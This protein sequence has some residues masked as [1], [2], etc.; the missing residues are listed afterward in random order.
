MAIVRVVIAVGLTV[1]VAVCVYMVVRGRPRVAPD[2]EWQPRLC[3]ACGHRFQGQAEP[4]VT[5][6]PKCREHAATR[7]Y[8][9]TCSQCDAVYDSFYCRYKD[10]SLTKEGLPEALALNPDPELEYRTPGGEWCSYEQLTRE[11][12]CPRCGGR[13]VPAAPR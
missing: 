10:A 12:N 1:V 3:E 6:C 8:Q 4:I 5:D 7:V 13:L 2:A 11:T 9:C